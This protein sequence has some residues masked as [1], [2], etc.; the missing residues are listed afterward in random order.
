MTLYGDGDARF[1][2]GEPLALALASVPLFGIGGRGDPLGGGPGVDR[3]RK[4]RSVGGVAPN[5]S[6][7]SCFRKTSAAPSILWNV[8]PVF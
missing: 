3:R 7:E 8:C 5:S 2:P 4:S 6:Q 1:V